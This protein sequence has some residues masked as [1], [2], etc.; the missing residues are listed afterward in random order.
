MTAPL[1]DEVVHAR[2]RLQ[3]CALLGDVESMSF[4]TVR[5]TLGVNDYVVSKHVKVLVEAGYVETSKSRDLGRTQ[6]WLRLTDAGRTAFRGHLA[7]LHEITAQ[8]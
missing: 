1:F 2:N 6:T 5:E 4:A 3:I 7:A 8:H